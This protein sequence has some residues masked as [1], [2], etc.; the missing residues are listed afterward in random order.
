MASL[1]AVVPDRTPAAPLAVVLHAP[2]PRTS[3]F[4]AGLVLDVRA[5]ANEELP[6]TS[7]G[8]NVQ[9]AQLGT[10]HFHSRWVGIH[11]ARLQ[12]CLEEWSLGMLKRGRAPRGSVT[13]LVPAGT[14]GSP[15]LQGRRVRAGG[16]L[17]LFDGEE[18]DYRSSGAARL[19]SISVERVALESHLRAVL[20]RDL[21]A[22]RLEGR[23]SGV[24][25]DDGALFRLGH[26][27]AARAADDTHVLRDGVLAGRL[28]RTLVQ[29][30]FRRFATPSPPEAAYRGR[31]LAR[32]AEAWLRQNLAEPLTIA[33][34][35]GAVRASERTLHEAFREHFDTT[36]K[37]YLKTLRLN[38]AHHDLRAGAKTR[39][40]DVALDWGFLHFGWFSQDYRRLFGETPSQ[41]L[42]RGRAE[43]ASRRARGPRPASWGPEA[44]RS[45]HGLRDVSA[46]EDH[47]RESRP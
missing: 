33:D 31:A 10:G 7:V 21:A 9:Y 6:G 46:A 34:L 20:G 2:F 36:P 8:W 24:R 23:L 37:A 47:W 43:A 44:A 32:R 3:L 11:T 17:V 15:R 40:T 30:L 28:E 14:G 18:F 42:H 39:V 22:L 38:A 19:V 13:F 4:P 1:R 5:T 45:H 35:C 29:A 12:M 26:E 25:T 27:L 16:V 41:T